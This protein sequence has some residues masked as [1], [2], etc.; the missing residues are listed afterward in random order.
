MTVLN[1]ELFDGTRSIE[2]IA[3]LCNCTK[4][5]VH[6][7]AQKYKLRA[8]HQEEL[9]KQEQSF[10]GTHLPVNFWNNPFN[11]GVK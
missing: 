3:K 1:P 6:Y 9:L 2:E 5:S 7:Y 10:V 8:K 4:S 11:L